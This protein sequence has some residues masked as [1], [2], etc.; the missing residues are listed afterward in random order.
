MGTFLGYVSTMKTILQR[1]HEAPPK[2][3]VPLFERYWQEQSNDDKDNANDND[4]TDKS[5]F[6][7]FPSIFYRNVNIE[8]AGPI[9]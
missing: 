9:L 7:F 2:L 1:Y 3:S 5:I 8:T 6:I 4:D